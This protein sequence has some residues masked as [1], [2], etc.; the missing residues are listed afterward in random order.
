[1]VRIV[2]G[3]CKKVYNYE[4][5]DFCPRCGAYNPPRKTSGATVRVDGLNESGHDGSFAHREFHREKDKRLAVGL[6]RPKTE[7]RPASRPQTKTVSR[8]AA[9]SNGKNNS[10]GIVAV[11][12]WI[13]VLTQIL[14]MVFN[15][16]F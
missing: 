8:P 10:A 11:I 13:I 1:M 14:R 15:M 16:L 6:D 2:C 12:V 9:K 7:K 5:D 3:E 4:E